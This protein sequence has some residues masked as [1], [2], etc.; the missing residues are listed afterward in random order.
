MLYI[1]GFPLEFKN[2]K[3]LMSTQFFGYYGQ[4]SKIKF[5]TEIKLQHDSYKKVLSVYVTYEEEKAALRAILGLDG[6]LFNG[7]R[8]SASFGRN[9]YCFFFLKKL[10]CEKTSCNFLHQWG[11]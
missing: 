9:K 3:H 1:K 8:L 10:N 7:I 5:G 6:L 4:V 2:M 11:D